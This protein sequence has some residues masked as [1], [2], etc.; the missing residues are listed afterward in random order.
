MFVGFRCLLAGGTL[1]DF[2]ESVPTLSTVTLILSPRPLLCAV[3]VNL[4][5]CSESNSYSDP[6]VFGRP[7][8]DYG[9]SPGPAIGTIE[10]FVCRF[11]PESSP[12]IAACD[13][14]VAFLYKDL[15]GEL[16]VLF[17]DIKL[18]FL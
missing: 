18:S 1:A 3:V 17:D 8:V 6:K 14:T 10:T 2:F 12:G 7:E 9:F 16:L 13:L 15:L 5:I 4:L 11:V